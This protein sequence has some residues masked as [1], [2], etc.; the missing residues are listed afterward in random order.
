MEE[1]FNEHDAQ[2][3]KRNS[4]G[5]AAAHGRRGGVGLPRAGNDIQRGNGSGGRLADPAPV[6]EGASPG[7]PVGVL[8]PDLSLALRPPGAQGAPAAPVALRQRPAGLLR[9]PAEEGE[10]AGDGHAP[11][12]PGHP[13]HQP[14]HGGPPGGGHVPH[15]G[16]PD[17]PGGPRG[18]GGLAHP[19]ADRA[20][21][22]PGPGRPV[23]ALP[24][25]AGTGQQ[26]GAGG[27]EARGAHRPG[28]QGGRPPG[29]AGGDDGPPG[30]CGPVGGLHR[31]LKGTGADRDPAGPGGRPSGAHGGG[32]GPA[33]GVPVPELRRPSPAAGPPEHPAPVPEGPG[34]KAEGDLHPGQREVGPGG[35][36]SGDG[37][38]G[39]QGPG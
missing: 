35:G 29:G 14:D 15:H 22:H 37:M 18:A 6:R 23:P 24:V 19:A 33:P 28:H 26:D 12:G 9:G 30:G 10:G 21:S 4:G 13:A 38:A 17:L 36:P 11:R 25:G 2:D 8:H 27:G 16:E 5:A 34:Q 3:G 39:G 1:Q 31:R 20:V 7:S 32:G